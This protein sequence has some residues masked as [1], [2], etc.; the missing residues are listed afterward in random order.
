MNFLILLFLSFNLYASGPFTFQVSDA[1]PFDNATNGFASENAQAAIE[2]VAD[3]ANAAVFTI[4]LVYNG[5][6]SGTKFISYSNLTPNS[7]VIVPINCEF[8]GFTYSNSKSG[9]DYTFNF[10]NNTTTGTPFFTVSKTNTQFF[11]QTLPTPETFTAGSE[12][13]I[14]YVDDGTNSNDGVWILTFKAL[15]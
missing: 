14:Q 1:V 10:R 11:A 12:I 8:V 5:T 9:A 4:P 6:L 13:S 3:I 2:E 7:P 15:P